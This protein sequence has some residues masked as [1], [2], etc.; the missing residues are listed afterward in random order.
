MSKFFEKIKLFESVKVC[1]FLPDVEL[2]EEAEHTMGCKFGKL[3]K[4][5]LKECGAIMFFFIEM[6]GINSNQGLNSDIIE[7]TEMLH[8]LYPQTKNLVAI[9]D[10]GDGDYILC[11]D[12]DDIFEFIPSL[13][14]EVKPLDIDLIKHIENRYEQVSKL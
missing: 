7:K 9:E 4:A 14:D 11:D 1:K 2:I 3:L 5:Y 13:S 10:M 12:N 6:Y 8:S